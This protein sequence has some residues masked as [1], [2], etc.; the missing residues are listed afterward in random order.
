[1]NELIETEKIDIVL[2]PLLCFDRKGFRVGYGKGFYDRFLKNCR[3][4]CLKIGLSYF[5]PIKEISDVQDF[6]VRLDF[7]ITPE[8]IFTTKTKNHGEERK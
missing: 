8:E 3:T 1:A 5:A 4:D 6:D 2:V 7:S